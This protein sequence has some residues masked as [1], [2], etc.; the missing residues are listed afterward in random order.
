M[1]GVPIV[2]IDHS[3]IR[4]GKLSEVRQAIDELVPFIEEREPQLLH[5]G[6]YVDEAASRLTV[7]AVHPDP[8]SVE[9]HLDVGGPAFRGFAPLIEMEGIEVYGPTSDR[10]LE[11]LNE[12]A[13]VLGDR[14]TVVV[15][16][17][18]SGFARGAANA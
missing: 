7:I 4:P 6:F 16:G 13:A 2:Y 8:A 12:K 11:Q 14:G 9:L 5:Y 18:H 3:S 10:M 1:M 15:C 17:L